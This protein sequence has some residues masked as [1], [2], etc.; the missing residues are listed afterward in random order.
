MLPAQDMAGPWALA[1]TARTPLVIACGFLE[2]PLAPL[3][4]PR[5]IGLLLAVVGAPVGAVLPL[6]AETLIALGIRVSEVAF[7]EPASQFCIS[8]LGGRHT[9]FGYLSRISCASASS[10]SHISS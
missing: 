3:A 10:T 4:K 6:A 2:L 9:W 1:A 5:R 8:M 7:M